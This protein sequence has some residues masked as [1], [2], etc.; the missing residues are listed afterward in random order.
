MGVKS[1]IT[2]KIF[3]EWKMQQPEIIRMDADEFVY[4][5]MPALV[6]LEISRKDIE[7]CSIGSALERLQIMAD[8]AGNVRLYKESV[9]IMVD[10]YNDDPRELM[11]IQEVRNFFQKLTAEWPHWIW[12]LNRDMGSLNLVLCLLCKVSVQHQGARFSTEFDRASTV[13]EVIKDMHSRSNPL[14]TAYGIT[15]QELLD[16]SY[17]VVDGFM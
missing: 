4:H 3:E 6:V 13:I 2:N 14:L 15:E 16:S 5:T 17:G 9:A 8:N 11:E 7:S 10:G 1:R 12:F